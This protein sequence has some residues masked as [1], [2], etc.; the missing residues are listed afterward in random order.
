VPHAARAAASGTHTS[1]TIVFRN[2]EP[3]YTFDMPPP[4][5]AL[6]GDQQNV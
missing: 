1:R 2:I 3:L 6:A 5:Q 4:P